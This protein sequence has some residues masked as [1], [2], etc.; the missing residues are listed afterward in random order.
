MAKFIR[1]QQKSAEPKPRPAIPARGGHGGKPPKI[2][3]VEKACGELLKLGGLLATTKE[4]AAWLELSE[5]S[6]FDLFERE[7]A[8]REHYER[9]KEMGRISLRRYQM[10]L[11]AKNPTM[12]IF[13]GMNNL[14]QKD[15]RALGV[16]GKIEHEH[17]VIGV[18]LKDIEGEG[19][20]KVIEHDPS[21][22]SLQK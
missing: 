13:L 10:Q 7:P 14:G 16:S 12:A 19:A 6:L 9:G 4:C 3:D 21:I 1:P 17:T 2:Q 15:Y 18:L 11:A 20:V 22:A 8:T 5:P